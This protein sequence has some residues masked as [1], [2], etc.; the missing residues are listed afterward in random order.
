M[1]VVFSLLLYGGWLFLT[2][3][4]KVVM[5]FDYVSWTFPFLFNIFLISFAVCLVATLGVFLFIHWLMNCLKR[6]DLGIRE[7]VLASLYTTLIA[8]NIVMI[9]AVS[10][11]FLFEQV[12]S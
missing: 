3:K 11:F 7:Y 4:T 2:Y 10:L 5:S 8:S 12:A 9:F 1:N 6:N